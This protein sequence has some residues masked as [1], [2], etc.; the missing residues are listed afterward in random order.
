MIYESELSEIYEEHV[1][2]GL[3]GQFHKYTHLKLERRNKNVFYANVLEIGS[4]NGEHL[5][6]ISHDYSK[7]YMLDLRKPQ[8]LK[9]S[10]RIKFVE[11]DVHKLPFEAATFDRIIVTCV[12]HHLRNPM[13]ALSEISR[14]AKPGAEISVLLPTD[15]GIVFRLARWIFS[16][17]S[18]RQKGIKN[19]KLLRALQHR[20]HYASLDTIINSIF[21]DVSARNY[22]FFIKSYDLNLFTI[23]RIIKR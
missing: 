6:F 11:G 21:S 20:N 5:K 16:N 7:Y 4:G 17:K 23:Y 19:I 3:N 1:S 12:L 9:K 2:R 18:L 15:P 8:K 22:P 13:K 14:V 10:K